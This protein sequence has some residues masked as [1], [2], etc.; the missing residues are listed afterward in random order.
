MLAAIGVRSMEDL[1]VDIPSALRIKALDL[2]A[3]L[4]EHETMAQI[5][6]LAAGNRV[7]PDRL[8]FRGGG[9]YR[10]V[11]P[12]AGAAGPAQPH[13]FTAYTPPP[14]PPDPGPPPAILQVPPPTSG[15]TAPCRAH[16]CLC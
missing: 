16:A 10:G 12:A 7:F 11:V 13:V 4:S 3:G 1:L 14:A 6:S 2:P 5:S 15:P 9:G 8:T